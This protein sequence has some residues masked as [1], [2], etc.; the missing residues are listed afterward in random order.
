MYTTKPV[1][2]HCLFRCCMLDLQNFD[3]WFTMSLHLGLSLFWTTYNN[4]NEQEFHSFLSKKSFMQL[5]KIF[6]SRWKCKSLLL[7]RGDHIIECS[8]FVMFD[9][10]FRIANFR[11]KGIYRIEIISSQN[12]IILTKSLT[13]CHILL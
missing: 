13:F 9:T 2:S 12:F 5:K 3:I 1:L 10:Y 11:E 6:S 8:I 4:W 7:Y